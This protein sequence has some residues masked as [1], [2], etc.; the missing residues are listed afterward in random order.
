M[1]TLPK[2]PKLTKDGGGP[3]SSKNGAIAS[4]VVTALV[5]G[6]LIVFFL[7][8]YRNNVD[9]GGVPTRV[10]VAQKLIEKGASAESAGGLGLYK[11]TDIPKDQVKAGAVSDAAT[12]HGEI[13]TTEILPGQQLTTT[14]FKP[15]GHGL[16]TK[17][18]PNQRAVTLSF[19][20]AHGMLGKISTGDHVDVIAGFEV[21]SI[22]GGARR[23]V[24]K[25]IMQDILVLD[26]PAKAKGG[27]VGSQ[28]SAS[29]ITLRVR[30]TQ[31]A[32]L[33]FASDNG[34]VWVA[35]RPQNGESLPRTS[36]VT[37]ETLLTDTQPLRARL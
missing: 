29:D 37:L 34:K 30:D 2:P 8:Q 3:L 20:S 4:A 22:A 26:V 12:L 35:L 5:A 19:D 1:Q 7:Q 28:T 10:L 24:T 16:I 36:I 11:A 25:L 23:A 27:A 33:A 15:A 32:K 31:A 18:A 6:L 14:D 9:E 17:L 21:E 13:A